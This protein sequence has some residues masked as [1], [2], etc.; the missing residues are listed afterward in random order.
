MAVG[1]EYKRM[2]Q[3]RKEIWADDNKQINNEMNEARRRN[4]R[5]KWV[6]DPYGESEW[7]PCKCEGTCT[8]ND[9]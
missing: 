2:Q 4:Y 7:Q 9:D 6:T 8:C 5:G 3:L 1:D